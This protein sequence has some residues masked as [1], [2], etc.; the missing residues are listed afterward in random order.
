M[1]QKKL[2]GQLWPGVNKCIVLKQDCKKST[3]SQWRSEMNF[4]FNCQT[5][6]CVQVGVCWH[7]SAL[8]SPQSLARVN[9]QLWT[10]TVTRIDLELLGLGLG[11]W[12]VTCGLGLV[13]VSDSDLASFLHLDLYLHRL[14]GLDYFSRIY[15]LDYLWLGYGIFID[16][17]HIEYV[18][19]FC[20]LRYNTS[21]SNRS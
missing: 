1:N 10:V 4:K 19:G 17:T 12:L 6:S 18:Q 2:D 20:I 13:M 5:L 16:S 15:R 9:C 11:F 14:N 7:C 8:T 3:W 21:D